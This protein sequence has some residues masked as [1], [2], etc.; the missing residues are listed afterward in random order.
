MSTQ[1]RLEEMD[2]RLSNLERAH[3]ALSA[4]VDAAPQ[5]GPAP[6]EGSAFMRRVRAFME[7]YG[8]DPIDPLP[9]AKP[10]QAP[11]TSGP[12]VGP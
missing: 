8:T 9:E 4:R 11:P 1:D 12:Y 2:A 7:K 6:D 5:G 10:A 3:E